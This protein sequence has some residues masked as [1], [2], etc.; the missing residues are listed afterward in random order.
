MLSILTSTCT[1]HCT[2]VLL[3]SGSVGVI[4]D[5]DLFVEVAIFVPQ[6]IRFGSSSVILSAVYI[7]ASIVPYCK[8][9]RPLFLF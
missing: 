2:D 6:D 4:A 7:E 5:N 1:V 3:T 9:I 8:P